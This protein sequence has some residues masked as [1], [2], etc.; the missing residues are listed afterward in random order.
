MNIFLISCVIGFFVFG[1]V[2]YWLVVPML[3]LATQ[4]IIPSYL[5][6]IFVSAVAFV[7]ILYVG[8]LGRFERYGG[9]E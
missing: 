3:Q 5:I 1:A 2:M 8:M 6:W 4:G 7:I 9:N